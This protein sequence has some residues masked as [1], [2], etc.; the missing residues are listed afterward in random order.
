MVRR[1]ERRKKKLIF[2]GSLLCGALLIGGG[3]TAFWGRHPPSFQA[4]EMVV[5]KSPDCECC[6][7]WVKSLE[8]QGYHHIKVIKRE[9]MDALKTELGV[10]DDLRSC[11][12]ARIGGYVIEGHVPADAIDRLLTEHPPVAG[13]AS[14]GM[15]SGAPG[16]NGSKEPYTVYSFYEKDSEIFAEY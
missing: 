6:D 15:P 16:M 8:Q 7:G 1:P 11:H 13:L 9:D 12:T 2:S 10:T 3:I 14:P 5:Y 4:E